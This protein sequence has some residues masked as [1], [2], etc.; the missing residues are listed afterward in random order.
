MK[1]ISRVEVFNIK[2]YLLLYLLNF[3][4]RI[5]WCKS[6]N[7]AIRSTNANRRY[8]ILFCTEF[9]FLKERIFKL[10][11]VHSRIPILLDFACL[12][13]S[14]LVNNKSEIFIRESLNPRHIAINHFGT[15]VSCTST[16]ACSVNQKNKYFCHSTSKATISFRFLLA[17]QEHLKMFSTNIAEFRQGENRL[18][19]QKCKY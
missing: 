2:L 14:F 7:N 9:S 10:L 4:L 11:Y 19:K 15:Y 12:P 16:N 6:R 13:L 8:G 3:E 18:I 17:L 5:R 1:F